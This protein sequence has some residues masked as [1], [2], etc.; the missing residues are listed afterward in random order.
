V[1]EFAETLG[2]RSRLDLFEEFRQLVAAL[3][4]A[5]ID[6]AVAGALAVAVYGAPRAT[7]D[8]DL[9][10]REEDLESVRVLAAELGFDLAASPMDFESGV[11][12][13]RFT[14]LAGGEAL[15]LDLLLARGPVV[16]PF[17]DRQER[18]TDFGPIW[19]VSLESLLAMKALAARPR[20]LDDIRRLR[21]QDG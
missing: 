20:D 3:R 1:V 19:V 5:Q 17:E 15:T 10:V 16:E 6:Y 12:V 4:A 9:I 14:K 8:I 2:E 7:T 21:E 18:A 11:S 13:R